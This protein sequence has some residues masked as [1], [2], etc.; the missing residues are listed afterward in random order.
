MLYAIITEDVPDSLANRMN[1]RPAHLERL[2]ELAKVL[3]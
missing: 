1:S 2:R 3:P